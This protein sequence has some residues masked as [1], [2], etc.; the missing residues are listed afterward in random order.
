MK[1]NCKYLW[2]VRS[3]T[4]EDIVEIVIRGHFFS[5]CFYAFNLIADLIFTPSTN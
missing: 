3:A 5:D 4:I 1:N 2:V